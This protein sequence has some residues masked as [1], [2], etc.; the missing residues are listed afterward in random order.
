MWASEEAREL[1][2]ARPAR[3]GI[4]DLELQ[5]GTWDVGRGSTGVLLSTGFINP[6]KRQETERAGASS[7]APD[8]DAQ[9]VPEHA[10]SSA[11]L[12]G[13]PGTGKTTLVEAVAGALDWPF[14]EINSADLLDQGVGMVS[15]QADNLFQKIMQLDRC[16]VL[17]D[18]IDELIRSRT[19]KAESVERMFTTTMLPRLTRLWNSKRILFFVNTNSILNVDPAIRRN[20]RFDMAVFVL[21]PG[22]KNKKRTLRESGVSLAE[23]TEQQVVSAMSESKGD[24]K[25]WYALL[26]YPQSR[27]SPPA[28]PRGATLKAIRRVH[29][30]QQQC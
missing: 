1:L 7:F 6:I 18:E 12:F 8:P 5:G 19:G 16:V 22:W 27:A 4:K 20:Q 24:P 21:P 2:Q 14:I 30:S 23:L 9:V 10:A 17:L 15:A 26:T 11:I 13:P 3:K 25:A 29:R 28:C